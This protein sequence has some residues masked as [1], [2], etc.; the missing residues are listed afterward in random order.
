[1]SWAKL[2]RSTVI[3]RTFL[4][5]RNT[6]DTISLGDYRGANF[7]NAEAWNAEGRASH[8][9]RDVIPDGSQ[10]IDR[11]RIVCRE[12][13]PLSYRVETT[14]VAPDGKL[15]KPPGSAPAPERQN[16]EAQRARRTNSMPVGY[17]PDSMSLVY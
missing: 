16:S 1:L 8:P 7:S 11:K 17:H 3:Q 14:L 4:F 9:P 2:D 5:R 13:G 6:G 15:I 12:D 10:S